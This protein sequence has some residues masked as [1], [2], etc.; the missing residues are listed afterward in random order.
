MRGNDGGT[1]ESLGDMDDGMNS[2]RRTAPLRLSRR[3][4]MRIGTA[5]ALGAGATAM[6]AL[7]ASAAAAISIQP[8]I[9]PS[10]ADAVPSST[11]N[12]LGALNG[13]GSAHVLTDPVLAHAKLAE[14]INIPTYEGSG[15][16]VHPSVYY[17]QNAWSGYEYWMAYTPYPSANSQLE[18]P[19]IAVSH[20]GNTWITPDG[21]ANPVV[22]VAVGGVNYNSDPNITVG[23]DGLMYLFWRTVGV[24]TAGE[25]WYCRTSSNGLTWSDPAVVR[26]DSQAVRRLLSPSF[27]QLA[28]GSWVAYA[29]DIV[30]KPYSVV[31]L[32]A[33]TLSG[34]GTASPQP[35]K[36]SGNA[37]QPWHIDVHRV[38]GEWQMLVQDGGASGGDLW[39]AV[40]ADGLNFKAGGPCIA[41]DAGDWGSLY[42]KSC[43][44]PA[45]KDG[46]VGWD[47]W[48]TGAA[49]AASGSIMGRTFVGFAST[50][51]TTVQSAVV[52][53]QPD[54]AVAA[55]A[56]QLQLLTARLGIHPWIVG[57][58]FARPDSLTLGSADTGQAWTANVGAMKIVN[59]GATPG[60]ASNTRCIIDVATTDHWPSVRIDSAPGA[61][62]QHWIL[63]RFKDSNNFYR[64]GFGPGGALG[65][66]KL[67]AGVLTTIRVLP[68]VAITLPG[69]T[70]G[71]RCV[72][73]TLDIMVDNRLVGS[74]TDTSL[75]SGTSVGIQANDATAVFRSFTARAS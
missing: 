57:D 37:V 18:N 34:L 72:G 59:K 43:F 10:A 48:L 32:Q 35:V 31:R 4:M 50:Q 53:A 14:H 17:N 73:S 54:P 49:F 71:L 6:T 58:A 22:P 52:A 47:T 16:A 75:S 74:V 30:P 3:A 64:L 9:V 2:A 45:I 63:A 55:S 67:V 56:L 70:I 8:A 5:T 69:I 66:Q 11:L 27:S 1:T 25:T 42:Y 12:Y 15:V 44:V 24:P 38:A 60:G 36:I 40:S 61:T 23:I 51:Q 68:A 65:L 19:S 21:L 29:V 62:S 41:R 39:A 46:V 26:E 13:F 7:P 28:D 33:T 20:D